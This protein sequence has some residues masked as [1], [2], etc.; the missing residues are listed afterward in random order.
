MADAEAKTFTLKHPFTFKELDVKEVTLRRAK[1]ADLKAVD[2]LK[3]DVEK[4]A[5]LTS[6]LSGQP[7]PLIDELDAEDFAAVSEVVAGFLGA[8]L[9]TG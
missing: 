7:L 5:K 1:V 9:P 6:I 4:I 3:G 8:S 2:G